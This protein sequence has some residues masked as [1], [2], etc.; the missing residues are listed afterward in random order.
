MDWTIQEA[1]LESCVTVYFDEVVVDRDSLDA[2][3]FRMG[4][5]EL[6]VPKS[7]IID[8]EKNSIEVPEWFA[9]KEGLV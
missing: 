2:T 7:L 9:I 5:R 6:W 3:L 4:N 8:Q 1:S